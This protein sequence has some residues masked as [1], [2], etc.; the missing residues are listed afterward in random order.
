M[1]SIIAAILSFIFLGQLNAQSIGIGINSPHSSSILQVQSTSRGFLPPRMTSAQRMAI[2]NPLS[3]LT[4]YDV[5]SERM[6]TF[7]DGTWRYTVTNELWANTT[8]SMYNTTRDVGIG[9]AAPSEKLH[10]LGNIR[11]SGTLFSSTG[12]NINNDAG[13]LSF[14]NA[15]VDKAFVQLSGDNLRVGTFSSN[16]PGQFIVRT[17]GA[18][19]FV[20][21]SGGNVGIANTNPQQRLD[22]GG[23]MNITGKVM[24][25]ASTSSAHLLPV[26]YGR[27]TS[28]GTLDAGTSNF[29]ISRTETGIYLVTCPDFNANTVVV[30]TPTAV[31]VS[32]G[33]GTT[34]TANTLIFFVR[35]SNTNEF[36]N[37]Y[38]NFVAYS[39]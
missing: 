29:T 18:D 10:V 30:A 35:N 15:S 39:Y 38:F 24:R 34:S 27:I 32:I 12:I 3:G 7:I 37:A 21:E 4:V 26:A 20:V 9:T 5:D 13:I 36:I 33:A 31:N 6:Y 1:K 22:V 19:R 8:T 14:Q 23:N 25:T 16:T 11:L 2:L 28:S 17:G